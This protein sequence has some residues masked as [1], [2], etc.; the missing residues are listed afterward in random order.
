MSSTYEKI[1]TT[2]LGSTTASNTFS[3]IPTTYT[4]LVLIIVGTTTGASQL[5][6]QLNGVTTSTYSSTILSGNGTRAISVRY[7]DATS[8]QLGYDDYFSSSQTTAITHIINYANTTTNKTVISRTSNASVG[9]GLSV[10][11]SRSTSATTSITVFPQGSSW[12]SGT[13]FTLYGIKS[14]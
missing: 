14:E 4:D 11:L 5:M 7:S 2:T 3:S 9:A 12:S 10:G 1:A 8:M 6:M 13:T